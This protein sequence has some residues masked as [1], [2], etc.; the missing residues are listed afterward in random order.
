M[1]L[2]E[3]DPNNPVDR[4][5]AKTADDASK[6]GSLD[7]EDI[8]SQD[9]P[10]GGDIDNMDSDGIDDPVSTEEPTKPADSALMSRVQGHDY[11]QSYLHDDPSKQS[12]P[13]MIMSMGMSD[14]AN[15]R[16]KI[17][18]KLDTIAIAGRVGSYDNFKMKATSD[19][20]SFVDNIMVYKK[21]A[22]KDDKTTT[23]K[24]PKVRQQKESAVK[25]G[26]KFKAKRN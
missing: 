23:G 6:D 5:L 9:D 13:L 14:L 21:M 12:H 26:Q 25:P 4:E 24:K 10:L 15:L 18:V 20:L 19:M 16:Q 7:Q 2:F 1:R 22:A 3:L 11:I 17:R 8:A